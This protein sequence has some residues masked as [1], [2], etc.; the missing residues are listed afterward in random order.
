MTTRVAIVGCGY[1][2]CEL[3]RQLAGDGRTIY[4]VRRS[5]QGLDTVREAGLEPVRAD[6]TDEEALD[7]VPDADWVVF[8]ASAGGRDAESAR[9]TYVEGLSATIEAFGERERAPQRFVYTGSTGVYG[10]FD[11]DWVDEETP[12]DPTTE[13]QAILY[14]A[15]RLAIEYADEHGIAGTVAR[16]GGLYGPERY[17]LH[18]Y[19][20]GPVTEGYLNLVHR[21]DAAG[22]IAYLLQNGRAIGEVVNVVDNEP[23]S[24]HVLVDWLAAECGVEEPE[25]RTVEER[26]ADED[27]S[28]SARARIA[29]DK[30]CSNEKLHGLGYEFVYP[31]YREGY[32][33]A[34]EA[35]CG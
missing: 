11:G 35:Y 27:L 18:R 24:K 4:G 25:K 14:E 17:R 10:D 16:F 34:I 23:V 3:G 29:A 32:R 26:L 15:E 31:T 6:V 28:E 9:E 7:A 33:D 8:A 19:L 22:A 12:L 5:Q 2:G 20:D 21:D 13:R 1:V 30:R